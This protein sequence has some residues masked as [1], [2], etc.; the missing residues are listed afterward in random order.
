MRQRKL[1][2]MPEFDY[3]SE[4]LY[5]IT[6]CTK[7]RREYFGMVKNGK[8]VL[9]VYG[10]IVKQQ[11]LWLAKQYSYVKLDEFIVM[12]NHIHGIL[13]IE[14]VG[15]GHDVGTGRDLS[16]HR[17][18]SLQYHQYKI[19]SLSELIG[20]FKTTSS[21]L[22]HRMGLAEFQWQRSFYDRIIRNQK[23]L[24]NIRAY[25]HYNPIKWQRDRNNL[26]IIYIYS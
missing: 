6:V 12:P 17:D 24:N 26:N 14:E 21:K 10:R 11:W 5:F 1:N 2:R 18:L 8:M 20:A 16:L 22:I 13:V 7:D 19:K 9:N 15:T 4:G 3:S 25:I 23:E